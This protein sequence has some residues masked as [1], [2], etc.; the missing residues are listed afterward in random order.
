[1][2]S[3]CA[4]SCGNFSLTWEH[5]R[6]WW[7]RGPVLQ[8]Q[9]VIFFCGI[10]YYLPL[11]FYILL[12]PPPQYCQKI[13]NNFSGQFT[14]EKMFEEPQDKFSWEWECFWFYF[15]ILGGKLRN[16]DSDIIGSIMQYYSNWIYVNAVQNSCFFLKENKDY[17]FFLLTIELYCVIKILWYKNL[18]TKVIWAP[19]PKG[20]SKLLYHSLDSLVSKFWDG[21]AL[22]CHISTPARP[23]EPGN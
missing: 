11:I 3:P 22:S 17:S 16:S 5:I 9:F 8:G 10:V 7:P 2:L 1:M 21:V 12:A 6:K 13:S 19:G 4:L 18:Q 23:L 20:C 14:A 15:N